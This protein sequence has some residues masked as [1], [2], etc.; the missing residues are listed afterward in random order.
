MTTITCPKCAGAAKIHGFSHVEHGRCF[1]CNG[2]GQVKASPPSDRVTV[3][4]GPDGARY[5]RLSPE[6]AGAFLAAGNYAV[7][8]DCILTI[9]AGP[10][11]GRFELMAEL[12]EEGEKICGGTLWFTGRPGAWRVESISDS[13]RHR[14]TKTKAGALLNQICKA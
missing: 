10:G 6:Q 12:S 11:G 8:H 3:S 9:K 13:L 7:G 4:V 2:S 1:R 5:K 14:F